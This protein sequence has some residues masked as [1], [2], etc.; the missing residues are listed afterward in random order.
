M[1]LQ[2]GTGKIYYELSRK[3]M[4]KKIFP[5][6]F[7]IPGGPGLDHS[8]YKLYSKSLEDFSQV[9][10][11]DPRGCGKSKR[12]DLKN[13]QIE[14]NADDLNQLRKHLGYR[15]ISLLGTSYGGITALCYALKYPETINKLILV[16]TT[17]SFRF[18]K[19]A[20]LNL[21][22][23]GTR[24]QKSIAKH[25]WAGS[26][27]SDRHASDF[28]RKMRSLYSVKA[29]SLNIPY[30]KEKIFS[31]KVLNKGFATFL[32]S[33]NF[34]PYLHKIHCQT[35]ILAGKNDWMTPP[36]LSKIMAK[37]IPHAKL[38]IFNQCGHSVAIDKQKEYIELIRN[39][40]IEK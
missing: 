24:E 10:Y 18:I 15:K 31:H 13:Y 34:E 32:Q 33:F 30:R 27:T 16:A 29:D 40:L 25:L 26:F 6:L 22:Q 38:T 28:S 37:K 5:K 1:Y 4:S 2:I 3:K 35:L 12:F 39:F 8:T 20:K 17:P 36:Q 23:R 19:L 11:H 21:K 9:I 14:N 7:V